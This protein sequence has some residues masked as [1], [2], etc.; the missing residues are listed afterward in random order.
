MARRTQIL[1]SLVLASAALAGL[2]AAGA[3]SS[4]ARS[5]ELSVLGTYSTGIFAGGAQE[6]VA[7][8]PETDRLFVVNAGLDTV[9]VLDASDPSAPTKVGEID[10]S[11]LG[12]PN[13]VDVHDGLVAV[14]LQ[15]DPKTDPGKVAFFD[16][17][18]AELAAVT[19]GAL[20]DMLTFTPNGRFVLV[21]NEGEPSDN[22]SIDPEGSVSVIDLEG[23]I[24]SLSQADVRTAGFGAFTKAKLPAGV[25]I[26]GPGATVAQDLEPE[27]VAAAD[28]RTAWVTLQEA[29]AV[30]VIDVKRAVVTEIKALGL[31]DHSLPGNGL[32]PSDRDNAI[33]IAGWPVYGMYMP[34]GIEAYEYKGRTFY[35]T[36]NEGD[37]REYDDFVEEARVGSLALDP[38]AFPNA[39]FLKDNARLGR[40]TVSTAS[41]DTDGDGDF[42]QLHVFGGRS[43]T[44]WN[45]AGRI[46]FDSGDALE[47]LTSIPG[48]FNSNNDENDSADTRSDNKD[49][50]PEGVALGAVGKR[51]YAFVGLER[52]GG[53][54]VWDVTSPHVPRFVQYLSN[55]DFAGDPEA[56][57][58]GD[59]GPEGLHFI[60]KNDSPIGV[61]LLAVANEV[62]GTTTLYRIDPQP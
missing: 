56:G 6:I 35:V 16:A 47:R 5:I 33:A 57:T 11:E 15:A 48:E 23:G 27:Y 3:G 62:S 14:A 1:A 19:V 61:P 8:D 18:G 24:G 26:F 7:F 52:I 54:M 2:S 12:S 20:P 38:A 42:D 41:G 44:I 50:E 31:K 17:D 53:V 55:R 36:A 45:Q 22:Y 58:A 39:A 9:D 37:A 32:D 4:G 43:F 30:A 49:P 28:S 59:L 29:N 34:D 25:R 60:A 51:L 46:V 13:S 40:L 10:T 21:A